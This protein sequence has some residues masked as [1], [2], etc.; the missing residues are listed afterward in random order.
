MEIRSYKLCDEKNLFDMM[1]E[2]GAEWED[3]WGEDGAPKYKVALSNCVVFVA[4]EG[5]E[6]CGFVRCRDD[7]GF[8]VYINDLLVKEQ[9]RGK[10]TGRMLMDKVC[11]H[12]PGETVYV[13]SDVDGYYERQGYR[14][15]GTIFQLK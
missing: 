13:M 10:N 3:Y 5:Y 11:A 4:Y 14:R 7:Y 9:K 6:L 12:F 8:G 2:E 15:E 1:R